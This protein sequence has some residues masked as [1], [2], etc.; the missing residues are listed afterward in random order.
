MLFGR[1]EE[2]QVCLMKVRVTLDF[3][4]DLGCVRLLALSLTAV[5]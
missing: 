5:G 4:C 2:I 1:R 3:V